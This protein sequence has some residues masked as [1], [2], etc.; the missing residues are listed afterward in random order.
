MEDNT[1]ADY[2]HPKRVCKDFKI[3]NLGEYHNFY[4]QSDAYLDDVFE[5]FQN[6]YELNLTHFLF[7]PGLAWQAAFKK[8]KVKLYLLTDIDMLLMVEVLEE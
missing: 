6:I 5:T 8:I 1:D 4:V 7:A 3:N 2:A